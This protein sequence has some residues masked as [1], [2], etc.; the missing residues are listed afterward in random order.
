MSVIYLDVKVEK[1]DAVPDKARAAAETGVRARDLI[2]ESVGGGGVDSGSVVHDLAFAVALSDTRTDKEAVRGDEKGRVGEVNVSLEE[3]VTSSDSVGLLV[4]DNVDGL[5]D[6][7]SGRGTVGRGNSELKEVVSVDI[8]VATSTKGDDL[9]VEV[10]ASIER[11]EDSVSDIHRDGSTDKLDTTLSED[12]EVTTSMDDNVTIITTAGDELSDV[13][14][15]GD[16]DGEVGLE[17][18]V[19]VGSDLG[20]HDKVGALRAASGKLHAVLSLK[21]DLRTTDDDVSVSGIAVGADLDA[22]VLVVDGV[23]LVVLRED[24]DGLGRLEAEV[25]GG[26]TSGSNTSV[27]GISKITSDVE[28]D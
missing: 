15:D 21:S 26:I 5:S 13:G 2:G 4:G 1:V 25:A 22:S 9:S 19:D 3:N 28:E 18:V 8:H 7:V 23:G 16:T 14:L 12:R 17:L 20:E 10:E 27:D 24:L 11:L 6:E